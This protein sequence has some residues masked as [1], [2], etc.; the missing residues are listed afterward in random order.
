MSGLRL[1]EGGF[2][3]DRS[4]PVRFM[5]DGAE[6]T[7]FEGDTLASALLADGVDVVCR[8]P[9]LGR[10]RG[11]VSAGAEEPSAFVEVRTPWFEPIV[12]ATTV[13]VVE[14]LVAGGRPGGGRLVNAE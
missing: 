8:S 6:H 1:A 9:I 10:P 7:G 2:A 14:G 13:D 3:I 11:V 5:F 12:A 4:R